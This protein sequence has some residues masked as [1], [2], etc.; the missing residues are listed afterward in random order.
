MQTTIPTLHVAL[1]AMNE[2]DYIEKT[3]ECL[4][5]QSLV[6]FHT[7][8]CV[9]QP[10]SWR[11]D[12]EKVHICQNN[13]HTLELLRDYKLPNLHILDH[14]SSGRGWQ[15]GKLGVGMARKTL[16]DHIILYADD[17]DVIVSMDADTLFGDDY[18]ASVMG[19]FEQNPRAMGLAN[20]YY[21]PLIEDD[22][23]NRAILRYEIYMRYYALNMQ[24]VGT[25][26]CFTPLGSAMAAPVW[27]CKKI[28]GLTPKKSGEDFY[29]LQKLTKAGPLLRYN[30][31][32]VY[33]GTRASDRVFFGTGPAVIKGLAGQW[34]AY[35][36]F[37]PELFEQVRKTIS[38]FPQ[39]FDQSIPTPMDSFFREQ[40]GHNDIF[41]PLRKNHKIR[42]KF[43]QACHEKVDGLRILQFLKLNHKW[44]KDRDE[45]N[46]CD[47][48][49]HNFDTS[50]IAPILVSLNFSSTTVENINKIRNFLFETE[51]D[52]LKLSYL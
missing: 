50:S 48:L 47:F 30:S 31:E 13:A 5:R 16:M 28:G 36:L 15:P 17:H 34:S 39:L 6:G 38:L 18:L 51:M 35:P 9:N 11:N 14:S 52:L 44:E 23:L 3:L 1:P 41:E 22:H 27:A 32:V 25:P 37:D 7:W 2:M 4:Q 49:Q 24:F 12:P 42:E 20:P 29:F 26:Y 19:I 45:K 40:F 10:E 43:V 46:L 33:P 21:H 8:V